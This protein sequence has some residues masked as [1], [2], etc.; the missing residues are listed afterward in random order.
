MFE[1]VERGGGNMSI[2]Q[3][4]GERG[5]VNESAACAIDDADAA[6]CFCSRARSTM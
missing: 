1:N 3:G 5:F 4:A 2:L 6:F